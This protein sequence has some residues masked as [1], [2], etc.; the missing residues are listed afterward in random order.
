[1]YQ[2]PLS[3]PE[4][5]RA[6]HCGLGR[7]LLHAREFGI[8]NVWEEL[9]D[10]TL[11]ERCYDWQVDG[12]RADW[13][14]QFYDER[15]RAELCARLV[16]MLDQ[17]TE[18]DRHQHQRARVA[19]HLARHGFEEA[20]RALARAW[21]RSIER[22]DGEIGTGELLEL[23]GARELRNMAGR[24]SD[25]EELDSLECSYNSLFGEGSA[26]PIL[27]EERPDWQPPDYSPPESGPT[28]SELCAGV[29][30]IQLVEIVRRE[31]AGR[32]VYS[33]KLD[34]T[35]LF[36]RD[37]G[38]QASIEDTTVVLNALLRERGWRRLCKFLRVF[39]YTPMPQLRERV[40]RLAF[41][42]N[43]EVRSCATTVLGEI[44]HERVRK[45]AKQK[46]QR[47]SSPSTMSSCG[48]TT[49]GP[50]T[51]RAS[52]ALWLGT[53][54]SGSGTGWSR[55]WSTWRGPMRTR[56]P[57]SSCSGSMRPPVACSAETKRWTSCASGKPYLNGSSAS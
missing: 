25:P 5:R 9:L 21:E 34:G 4:F 2:L 43:R 11:M 44:T 56:T 16:P 23:G 17:A 14:M 53:G 52:G 8:D 50:V 46:L 13:V 30:G 35:T 38:R 22:E 49:T 55:T 36:F 6:L 39:T 20:H 26:R 1:M 57:T 29:S 15:H 18:S 32:G 24:L 47:P 10:V 45:L 37:W 54:K 48:C 3:I 19:F 12:N 31:P 7:A 33:F 51:S 42:S 41:H 27:L 28:R 40:I